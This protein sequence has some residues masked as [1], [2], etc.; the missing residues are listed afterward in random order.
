MWRRSCRRPSQRIKRA[1][2][3]LL[4]DLNLLGL[5]AL[6]VD[7]VHFADHL[8]AVALVIDAVGTEHPLAVMQGDAENATVVRDSS[9]VCAT[10]RSK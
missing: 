5:V 7:R 10:G 1:F 6:I 8:R 3:E 9:V 4:S 2:D